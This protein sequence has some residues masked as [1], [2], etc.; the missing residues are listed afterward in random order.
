[1][2]DIFMCANLNYFQLQV[3]SVQEFILLEKNKRDSCCCVGILKAQS[4][5]L[6]DSC[7]RSH[8]VIVGSEI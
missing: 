8:L 7:V 6:R 5:Q 3:I 2:H 4:E 1:M